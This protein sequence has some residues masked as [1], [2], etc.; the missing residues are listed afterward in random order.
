MKILL[1]GGSSFTGYWFAK[2]LADA[3]CHVVA[4]VRRPVSSYIDGMRAERVKRLRECAEVIGD[5]PFGDIR[6]MDLVRDGQYDVFCHHAARVG[7]YRSAQFDIVAALEENTRNLRAVLKTLANKGLKGLVYTGSVFEE[8][9][10]AGNEPLIAFSAYG[11]AKG[12][13][14]TVMR[15][16]CRELSMPYFKFV[17]PNPFGP[18][19]EP[20]FCAYLLRTWKDNGVA[21]VSTPDYVRD[22]IH[23]DLLARAYAQ[24]VGEVA[25]GAANSRLNPSGYVG[26]QRSFAKHVAAEMRPRLGLLCDLE[27]ATQN[28][29]S[30]PL[31]RVN[32]DS[33]AHYVG[34]WDEEMAWTRLADAYR[35]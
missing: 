25:S 9:E 33:A 34:S 3:G 12:L 7:D 26:T 22:N 1:T 10:G 27:F 32:T 21:R 17:I 14:A 35:Q 31:M 19:E 24:Y 2:S 13:T 5:C 20:R 16:R 6:F 4:P 15:H 30:E 8:N 18:L 11:L 23:V 28:D 29:F